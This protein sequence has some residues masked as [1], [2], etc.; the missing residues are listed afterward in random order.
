MSDNAAQSA[1]RQETAA[2]IR[3][4]YDAFNAGD[5]DTM[6][7]FLTDDVIHDVNQG[8]RRQGKE[9]F[10]AFNARMAHHYRE[11][12]EDVAVMVGRDGTRAAAE[13]NVVGTY[14]NTDQ[15]LPEAKGQTYRLPA[16]T[17]FE[18]R[19]GKIARVTTYYNLT[20]WIA[21]VAG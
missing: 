7:S 4:Y 9:K 18:V 10:A 3:R 17:F 16:G 21:Q 12:L 2:L 5:S 15:G 19:A 11:Q 14:L 8:E 13:F 20:D 6:L 1:A